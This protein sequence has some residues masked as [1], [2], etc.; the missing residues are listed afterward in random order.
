LLKPPEAD[1]ARVIDT[2]RL[3]FAADPAVRWVWPDLHE[4]LSHSSSFAR[5]FGGKAFA[6][7]SAHYVEKCLLVVH[8]KIDVLPLHDTDCF[9]RRDTI[10]AIYDITINPAP[11]NESR[12]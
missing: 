9:E 10:L 11:K 8:H 4:Y 3:A 1:E 12:K 2:L 5:A 6:N 7:K